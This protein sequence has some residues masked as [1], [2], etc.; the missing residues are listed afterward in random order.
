MKTPKTLQE[1]GVGGFASILA[2]ILL[3]LPGLAQAQLSYT[4]NN[5]TITITGGCPT[6]PGALIIPETING[7]PVT[8]VGDRAFSHCTRLTS[9]T[10]PNSVTNIGSQ[11]FYVCTSLTNVTMPNSVT[12]I[13]SQAFEV[14]TSLTSITIPNNVTTIGDY[15]F[16]RCTNLTGI[17][18]PNNVTSIG[19]QAFQACTSLTG[20]TIPNSVTNIGELGFAGCTSLTN[21]VI[22]NS[23][24]I[25][26]NRAFQAC[27]SL[28]A[29]EVDP[30]NPTYCSVSGVLFNKSQTGL[31]AYPGGK[32]GAYII[33]DTVSV[34]GSY[35]FSYCTNL[36][37]ITIPNSVRSI[38]P[39][40]FSY[41]TRLASIT[42]PNRVSYFSELAFAFCTNLTS[43]T[44]PNSVIY[45][46]SSAL[47]G[48]TRLKGAYFQG[49]AP[50]TGWAL[51]NGASYVTVYYL[52]GTTGWGPIFAGRPTAL[53]THPLLSADSA[54][55]SA[56]GFAFTIAWATNAT[57]VVEACLDLASPA[58][59][60]I[61]TN[62]PWSG[63]WQFTDLE[64][65]NYPT[66]FYRVRSP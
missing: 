60:P 66:R 7:L 13:G 3:A 51:F 47:E 35:A 30:A 41:C 59:S 57:L 22:G 45:I 18:I 46:G 5:G 55:V 52:P 27:T 31:I 62:T 50:D 42:I 25:I 16:A 34:V 53:W 4:T 15:T 11:A 65:T 1:L 20:I 63:T 54:G 19:N 29:I 21:V 6:S 12:S 44:I 10:I 37:S 32:T 36:T 58:W 39:W 49:N 56:N 48:C 14:C 17:T 8:T 28:T 9:I 2:A 38:W 24:T 33:P 61:A 23:V 26:G 40:A 43:I 64:W